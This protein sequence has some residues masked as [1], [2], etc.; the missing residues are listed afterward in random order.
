MARTTKDENELIEEMKDQFAKLKKN[1]QR[2][3]VIQKEAG[4]NDAYHH[5]YAVKVAI[6]QAHVVAGDRLIAAFDNGGEIVA[7]GGTR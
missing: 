6:E 2:L 3:M 4:R 5:A 7:L 1:A